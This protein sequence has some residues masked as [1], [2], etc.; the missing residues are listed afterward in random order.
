MLVSDRR[1]GS[2]SQVMV[3]ENRWFLFHLGT[4]LTFAVRFYFYA[5]T[6]QVHVYYYA[7]GFL[8]NLF[9][10]T[11]FLFSYANTFMVR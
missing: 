2:S 7:G 3:Q 5:F 11:I 9:M 1:R 10:S 8:S 6:I 4:P